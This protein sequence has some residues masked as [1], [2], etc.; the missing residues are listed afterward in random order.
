MCAHVTLPQTSD[1][2]TMSRNWLQPSV[3]Q[4]N[5]VVWCTSV[6]FMKQRRTSQWL[7]L[8]RHNKYNTTENIKYHIQNPRTRRSRLLYKFLPETGMQQKWTDQIYSKSNE[9]NS[10]LVEQYRVRIFVLQLC[11]VPQYVFL[12]NNSQQTS[13][14]KAKQKLAENMSRNYQIHLQQHFGS[15]N[16]P[17]L[18]VKYGTVCCQK[19]FAKGIGRYLKTS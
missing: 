16:Y 17:F 15:I 1:K 8:A 12:C 18:R 5:Y 6:S 2:T 11:N 7:T 4:R 14:D 10:N 13:A 3:T 19:R 9:K